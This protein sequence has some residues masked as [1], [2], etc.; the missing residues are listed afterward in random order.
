M[1]ELHE[2]P[3]THPAIRDGVQKI[4]T[5]VWTTR[6]VPVQQRAPVECVGE[7]LEEVIRKLE[8]GSEG[9]DKK[10]DGQQQKVEGDITVVDFCSGAGGPMKEIERL[11]K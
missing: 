3:W 7:V 6:I 9:M 4:L 11:L 1:I 2:Q 10:R 8:E 5:K